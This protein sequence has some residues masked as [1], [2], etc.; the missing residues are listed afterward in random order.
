MLPMAEDAEPTPKTSRE[1][2]QLLENETDPEKIVD[3]TRQLIDALDAE[4]NSA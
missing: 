4:E 1:L 2:E 3:L